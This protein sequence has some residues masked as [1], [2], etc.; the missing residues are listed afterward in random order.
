MVTPRATPLDDILAIA[1][2]AGTEE[3]QDIM[4]DIRDEL[5]AGGDFTPWTT[6]V[7]LARDLGAITSEQAYALLDTI[8]EAAI[9]PLIGADPTL[10]AL[11]AQMDAIKVAD[12]LDE[13]DDYYITEAPP[14][15]QRINRQWESR[16]DCMRAEMFRGIGEPGMAASLT[17]NPQA[18]NERTRSGRRELF[19]IRDDDD[20]DDGISFS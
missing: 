2:W 11:S 7:Q 12:G 13:D 6:A 5:E 20:A 16:M 15:W 14:E 18:F 4:A 1:E 8:T 3:A 19:E 10:L 17:L 9:W